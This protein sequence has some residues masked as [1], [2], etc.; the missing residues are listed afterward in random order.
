MET[1]FYNKLDRAKGSFKQ[2]V[3]KMKCVDGS[4]MTIFLHFHNVKNDNA[5]VGSRSKEGKIMST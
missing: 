3:D 2:Y 4:K 5:K 1:N